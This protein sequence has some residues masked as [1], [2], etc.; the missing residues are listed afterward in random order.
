MQ[1]VVV[2]TDSGKVILTGDLVTL[3]ESLAYD[4][5]RANA[6]LYDDSPSA[7]C[8]RASPR[9]SRSPG[10][11]FPGH[12]P[13]V[14]T[15][16]AS[17]ADTKRSERNAHKID[18]GKKLGMGCLR[19]PVFD[20]SKQAEIDMEAAQRT[21]DLFMEQGYNYFDTSYVY[22]SGNSEAA[23]G[24]LL[25]DKYPRDSFL[26]STKMP[27]KWMRKPEEQE[28]IF[29]EQL[30]RCHLE[31]FDFY[32]IHAIMRDTYELSKKWGTWDFLKQKRAEGKFR[33]LASPCT[34]RLNFWMR[35]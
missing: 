17:P 9:S 19:L 12:D 23:L 32:L 29:Q 8:S 26:I 21:I 2:D 35:F 33:N 6:L 20:E 4:P 1:S 10:T 5:P 11:S 7:R 27:L 28:T 14:F 24:K 13:G 18:F 31:Y 15:P 16:P 34:I 3:R 30:D 25:V 22:H